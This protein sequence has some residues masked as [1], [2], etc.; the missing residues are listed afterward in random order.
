MG[1]D[2]IDIH[3]YIQYLR[4]LPQKYIS[5]VLNGINTDTQD[6]TAKE[7]WHVEG[8]AKGS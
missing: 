4:I 7:V 2:D 1:G 3:S 8:V 6:R 5:A